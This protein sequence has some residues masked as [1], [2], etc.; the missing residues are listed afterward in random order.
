[1]LKAAWRG[2]VEKA[3]GSEVTGREKWKN[4]NMAWNRYRAKCRDKK[5]KFELQDWKEVAK[6]H[7][8]AVK[9]YWARFENKKK[10]KYNGACSPENIAK[11]L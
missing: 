6:L 3:K 1:M 5:W 9:E 2:E 10:R 11:F 8:D 7:K 4:A